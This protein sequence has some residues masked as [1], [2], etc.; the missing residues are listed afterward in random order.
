ME[1]DVSRPTRSSRANGPI[2]KLQPP[3]IAVSMS[4]IDAVPSSSMRMA[5]FRYGNNKAFTMKPARSSTWT[6]SLPIEVTNAAARAMVS[7]LAVI[8]RTI[9]TNGSTAAGLKKWIPQT[10]SG[11]LV[12]LAISTTDNVLVLVAKIADGFTIASSSPNSCCLVARSSTT[13]SMTMSQSAK[14]VSSTVVLILAR[15]RSRSL[16]SSLPLSTCRAR[17]PV[18]CLSAAAADDSLRARTIARMPP[19]AATSAIPAAM[20]PEP[21]TPMV[22]VASTVML[23]S[24]VFDALST[25][26][27]ERLR[28]LHRIST[29]I[30][31]CLGTLRDGE[32]ST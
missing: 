23:P 5:L 2:G 31:A 16:A 10:L 4:C 14:P 18:I 19:R 9:S 1:S 3:F 6:P 32:F 24:V 21:T 17:P 28:V 29:A 11:R 27:G 13:D 12:T 8:G 7:S 25:E 22:C 30:D 20:M 26:L 15:M